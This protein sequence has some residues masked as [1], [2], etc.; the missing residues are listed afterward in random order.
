HPVHARHEE[1]GKYR[2]RG[3]AINLGLALG[4]LAKKA[5]FDYV[6]AAAH[7]DNR[8]SWATMA[9]ELDFIKETILP[10]GS[11][12]KLYMKKLK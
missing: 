12:R 4:D 8:S 10:N 7:P 2:S 5:G 1:E 6:V 3:I 11:L 9:R